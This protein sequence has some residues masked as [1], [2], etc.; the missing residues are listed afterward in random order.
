MCQGGQLGLGPAQ[1]PL[2][3]HRRVTLSLSVAC[4]GVPVS[5]IFLHGPVSDLLVRLSLQEEL[6]LGT[7]CIWLCEEARAFVEGGAGG[8]GGQAEVAMR[9]PGS[10]RKVGATRGPFRAGFCPI[11]CGGCR[12]TQGLRGGLAPMLKGRVLQEKKGHRACGFRPGL[13]NSLTLQFGSIPV[14][15]SL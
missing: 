13:G 8:W 10:C 3:P 14:P 1:S 11:L 6:A 9:G 12:A 2:C 15:F 7:T 4:T 5:S